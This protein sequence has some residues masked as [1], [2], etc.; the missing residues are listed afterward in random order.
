MLKANAVGKI[1]VEAKR[2]YL[3]GLIDGDGCIMAT[4][5]R[6]R[7]KKFGFRVRVEI[8][9]T[10]KEKRLLEK[11]SK[12][13]KV[14]RVSCNRRNSIKLTHDW[15][16]RDKTDVFN[17]LEVIKLFSRLKFRQIIIAQKILRNVIKTPRDLLKN[18]QLAD[19]LSSLNVRSKN[20]RKNFATM[21]KI[22][23]SS[24]D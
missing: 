13:F 14:G 15:I 21:I 23:I 20:R 4:I 12:E 10:L 6:H 8:K 7:E 3:A 16:I 5:E 11:L 9:L 1:S 24:N 19:T 17:L 18:A 22:P 2:A